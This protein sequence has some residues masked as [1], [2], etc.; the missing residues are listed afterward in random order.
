[1]SRASMPG[2]DLS[3]RDFGRL[4]DLIRANL[5]LK[6]PPSKK[7]MI[8][9]R[10]AKRLR[11]L[12]MGSY[13]QYCDY[14]FSPEGMDKELVNLIDVVTTN[15]TEFFR[16]PAAFR[17]LVRTVLPDLVS[18]RGAGVRHRLMVWSAGCSTGEEPF[19]L[20]MVLSEFAENS[21]GGDFDFLILATDVSSKVLE[22]ARL[23]VYDEESVQPI[24]EDLKSKYLLRG[25][26]HRQGLFRIAPEL[27]P[28]IRFHRLNLMEEFGFKEKMDVI[29]C[30]NVIIYFDRPTQARLFQRFC[31]QL[32]Q[33]GYVFLG[34]SES[35]SGLELPLKPVAPMIY[36][37]AA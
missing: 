16:E 24:P 9:G 15:K 11:S 18:R 13:R 26:G 3:D 37:K 6:M 36:R 21:P 35:L 17:H 7:V 34:H 28:R 30:R 14:L 23:A 19:T 5:G 10:L 32:N 20:A 2:T 12:E 4:S 1:M 25:K 8:E 33:G 29:F 22:K 27:R 31:D